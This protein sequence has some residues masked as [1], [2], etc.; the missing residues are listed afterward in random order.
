MIKMR[1]N[2]GTDVIP[3][4]AQLY[5]DIW[6]FIIENPLLGYKNVSSFV[7]DIKTSIK[8]NI[9]LRQVKASTT[10]NMALNLPITISVIVN[11]VINKLSIVPSSFSLVNIRAAKAGVIITIYPIM[12]QKKI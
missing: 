6:T 1:L 3:I 9:Q 10:L 4:P 2:D 8:N 5:A 7:F 12:K 11:G